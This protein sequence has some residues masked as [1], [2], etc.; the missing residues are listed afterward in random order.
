[1]QPRHCHGRVHSGAESAAAPV[2]VMRPPPRL[3]AA[4]T[5]ARLCNSSRNAPATRPQ[6]APGLGKAVS[7]RIVDAVRTAVVS[8]VPEVCVILWARVD[9]IIARD[10]VK[11]RHPRQNIQAP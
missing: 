6:R 11:W 9:Q 3:G 5:V 4:L 2:A 8:S 10:A 7:H 1:M